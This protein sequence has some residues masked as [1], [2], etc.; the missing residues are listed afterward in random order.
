MVCIIVKQNNANKCDQNSRSLGVGYFGYLKP[1]SNQF[2]VG[3][4]P[5]ALV[6]CDFIHDFEI[7]M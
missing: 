6:I 2:S 1:V 7:W 4:W 5:L 3:V